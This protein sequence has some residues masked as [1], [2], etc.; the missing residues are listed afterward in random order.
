[1]MPFWRKKEEKN[2]PK[3]IDMIIDLLGMVGTR[4]NALE[5]DVMGLQAKFKRKL[6]PK[7]GEDSPPEPPLSEIND[8]FDELRK[9]NKEHTP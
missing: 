9:I 1:M 3:T 6:L 7:D 5:A 8:G 2:S 4:L